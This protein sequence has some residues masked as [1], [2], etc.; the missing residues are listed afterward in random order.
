MSRGT[1]DPEEFREELE[2]APDNRA[3]GTT[4][5]F[6]NDRI[7][8]WELRLE[9][10]ERAP[11]HCHAR[12]YFWTVVSPGRGRQRFADGTWTERDYAMGETKFLHHSPTDTLIHDLENVGEGVLRFVTVELS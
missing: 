10:G 4:L 11:F 2:A 3:V 5:W 12:D 8:V 1:F 7:K 9:P 6:E